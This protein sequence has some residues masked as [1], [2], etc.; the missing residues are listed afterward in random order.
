[1]QREN[2]LHQRPLA[3]SGRDASP[4]LARGQR[5]HGVDNPESLG[6]GERLCFERVLRLLVGSCRADAMEPILDSTPPEDAS[7]TLALEAKGMQKER[8]TEID[9]L[10]PPT[11]VPTEP[12]RT[13]AIFRLDHPVPQYACPPRPKPQSIFRIGLQ[14]LLS[15][16]LCNPIG[17]ISDGDDEKKC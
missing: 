4:T 7:V 17:Q 14:F 9:K 6:L 3:L 1:M 12:G 15:L 8:R 2:T 5:E 13:P 16:L 11:S 10:R